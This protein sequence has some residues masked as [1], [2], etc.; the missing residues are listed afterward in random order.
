M[1]HLLLAI[2]ATFAFSGILFAADPVDLNT[3]TQEQLETVTGIGPVKAQA[4]IEYREANG[5]FKS[6]D[7]LDNVKGFGEKGVAKLRSQVTVGGVEQA[8]AQ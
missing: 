8:A 3:A 2:I 4:I 5:G 1:K 6:V 7:D